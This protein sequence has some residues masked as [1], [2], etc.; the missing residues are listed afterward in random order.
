M[1]G[2]Q[3]NAV[4]EMNFKILVRGKDQM[5]PR[6]KAQSY[7]LTNKVLDGDPM[8]EELGRTTSAKHISAD[9]PQK[10]EPK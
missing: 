9:I 8:D 5:T 10:K 7:D 1:V 4:E 3:V 6:H 2:D